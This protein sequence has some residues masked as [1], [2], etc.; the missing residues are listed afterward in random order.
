MIVGLTGGI[1]TGK[2]TVS[3]LLQAKGLPVIDADVLAREVVA[4][5]TKGLAQIVAAFGREYLQEDGSLDRLRLGAT[6]FADEAMR[7]QLNAIVHPLV[8]SEMWRRAHAI[9]GNSPERIAILDVPLLIEGGTHTV[10]DVTVLVYAPADVQLARLMARNGLTEAQAHARIAAQW[11]I[12]EKRALADIVLDNSGPLTECERLAETLC[13]RLFELAHSGARM[14]GVFD[15]SVV[16][17]M[18]IC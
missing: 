7:L 16:K 2:S 9:V 12:E 18:W 1:A 8:R 13:D 15:K 11:S 6:V 17:K 10:V 3:S 14:E 4:P 5:G